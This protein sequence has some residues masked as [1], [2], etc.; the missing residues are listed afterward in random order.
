[1]LVIKIAEAYEDSPVIALVDLGFMSA[2][3]VTEPSVVTALSRVTD[4][5][6]TGELLRPLRLIDDVTVDELARCR[7]NTSAPGVEVEGYAAN[8]RKAEPEEG[9]DDYEPRD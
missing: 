1:M 2:R 7:S 6:L 3:W 8:R 9:D 4:D 5:Q